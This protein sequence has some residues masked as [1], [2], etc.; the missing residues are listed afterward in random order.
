MVNVSSI[1]IQEPK[2]II[3]FSVGYKG[4]KIY[5]SLP[6]DKKNE[7]RTLALN[8]MKKYAPLEYHKYIDEEINREFVPKPKKFYNEQNTIFFTVP[9]KIFILFR[10]FDKLTKSKINLAVSEKLYELSN[11]PEMENYVNRWKRKIERYE[12]RLKKT[13]KDKTHI[14]I[15]EKSGDS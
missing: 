15:I 7:V 4:W 2:G 12:K 13:E 14:Q 5:N 11:D 8:E 6:E 10:S 3:Y 1:E 9:Y